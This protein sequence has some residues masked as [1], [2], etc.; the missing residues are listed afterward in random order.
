[1]TPPSRLEL[2]VQAGWFAG[3]FAA[4]VAIYFLAVGF[5]RLCERVARRGRRTA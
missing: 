1:M 2:L 4:P 3:C 5:G